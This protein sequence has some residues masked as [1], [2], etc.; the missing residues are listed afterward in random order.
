M[1]NE[2]IFTDLEGDTL[3][4][5]I[6]ADQVWLKAKLTKSGEAADLIFYQ[7]TIREM[8]DWLTAKLDGKIEISRRSE[9]KKVEGGQNKLT[10]IVYSDGSVDCE[11]EFIPT[12]LEANDGND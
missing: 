10:H 9:L 6:I 7:H 11:S 5:E 2:R 8:I 4:I 3:E 12:K 1:A